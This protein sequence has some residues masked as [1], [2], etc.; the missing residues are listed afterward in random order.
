MIRHQVWTKIVVRLTD[1]SKS[2]FEPTEEFQFASQRTDFYCLSIKIKLGCPTSVVSKSV[3]QAHQ[4]HL[5]VA[6]VS[7]SATDYSDSYG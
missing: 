5:C 7:I 2:F 6:K 3:G 4:A 1:P